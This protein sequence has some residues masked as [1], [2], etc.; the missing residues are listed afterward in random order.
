MKEH[1]PA[2][3]KKTT[4]LARIISVGVK[5]KNKS[6]KQNRTDHQRNS[7]FTCP[8]RVEAVINNV[9]SPLVFFISSRNDL[10]SAAHSLSFLFR[11]KMENAANANLSVVCNHISIRIL[12]TTVYLYIDRNAAGN[13]GNAGMC[14]WTGYGF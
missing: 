9:L 1:L 8:S 3:L 6:N 10:R 7:P 2:F 13:W 5:G 11:E 4:T 12:N 14:R